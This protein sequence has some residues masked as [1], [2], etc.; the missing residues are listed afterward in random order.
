M[1]KGD[2]EIYLGGIMYPSPTEVN[3]LN[4]K[5]S[6]I[7]NDTDAITVEVDISDNKKIKLI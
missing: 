5:F 4:E 2:K 6:N 3:Y 7:I 1:A